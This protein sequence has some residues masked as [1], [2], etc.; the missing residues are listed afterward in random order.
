VCSIFICLFNIFIYVAFHPYHSV[1]SSLF[2]N[3]KGV[4]QCYVLFLFLF[5][6]NFT[7]FSKKLKIIARLHMTCTVQ[8]L[9]TASIDKSKMQLVNFTK[10]KRKENI[11]IE[12]TFNQLEF[13]LRADWKFHVFIGK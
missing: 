4:T 1:F 9:L 7:T 10:K 11:K 12:N 13:L 3:R 5:Y 2:C 8:S 6:H